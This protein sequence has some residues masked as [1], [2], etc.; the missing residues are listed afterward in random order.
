MKLSKCKRDERFTSIAS[1]SGKIHS[2]IL[3]FIHS[4]IPSLIHSFI[5]SFINAFVYSYMLDPKLI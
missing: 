2:F 1:P 5:H 4:F 3:P